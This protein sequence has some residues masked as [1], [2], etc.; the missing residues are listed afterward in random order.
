M[1]VSYHCKPN[2]EL[3]ELYI[4]VDRLELPSNLGEQLEQKLHFVKCRTPH[5]KD[6]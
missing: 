3:L 4:P 1:Q 2:L 6:W 5:L